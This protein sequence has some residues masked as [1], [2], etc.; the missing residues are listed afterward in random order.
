MRNIIALCSA[1]G[2][3]IA[4]FVVGRLTAPESKIPDTYFDM[5]VASPEFREKLKDPEFIKT[6]SRLEFSEP[7]LLTNSLDRKVLPEGV[8]K[9]PMGAL[10]E[11]TEDFD[12]PDIELASSTALADAKSGWTVI[13]LWATWCAPCVKELPDIDLASLAYADV[14]VTLLTLNADALERDTE[15]VVQDTFDKRGVQ[16]LD[17]LVATGSQIKTVLAAFGMS[18]GTTQIPT[19]I[20]YAPDGTP[21]ALFTG[22]PLGDEAVWNTPEMVAFFAALAKTEPQP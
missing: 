5:A 18:K 14:G 8:P 19:N 4:G 22:G 21:F 1:V 7:E 13:N 2:L 17:V 15:A 20:I 6:L 10:Y 3:A 11:V 9:F 16:H 12:W